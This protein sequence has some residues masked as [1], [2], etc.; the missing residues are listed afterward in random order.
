MSRTSRIV[1]LGDLN[2]DVHA[3]EPSNL[4]PGE[5]A[6]D[7]V[8]VTAGGSAGTFARI[9]AARGASVTFLGCVGTDLV[10]D[11]LIRSLGDAGVETIVQRI[12]RPSGVILALQRGSERTMVCSR[13]ANDGIRADRIDGS[14]FEGADHLHVSGYAFL[15]SAQRPAVEHAIVLAHERRLS[16]SVDPPPANLIRDH[17]VEAFL[18]SLPA[19]A[20]LFPNR[21]EGEILAGASEPAAIVGWLAARFDVGA[22]TLGASGSLAWAGETRHAQSTQPLDSVDTTGAGDAFAGAFV[23]AYLEARDVAWANRTACDAAR[24]HLQIVGRPTP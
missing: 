4:A 1:V 17:G 21:T 7:L 12:D 9:A 6:R 5:E 20:W 18:G 23:A 15:S 19:G 22:L 2:L 3:R 10:G 11:L 8:R 14:V 13:G 16:I 24:T